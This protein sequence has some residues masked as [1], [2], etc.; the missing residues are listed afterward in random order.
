MSTGADRSSTDADRSSAALDPPPG[1]AARLI[2]RL[3]A[4]L[5]R[6]R[7]E[8]LPPQALRRVLVVRPDDRV[9]NVLLT[10]P[11]VRALQ[12]L[13]PSAQVELLLADR[14]ACIAEG[15]PG[16]TVVRFD[17][18]GL[19]R[20]PL[21]F[22]RSLARLR[23]YDAAIDA[24]HW[25]A[26]SLTAALL[27]RWAGRRA[28]VGFA[29]APFS[30]IYS[31]SLALPDSLLPD[32]L[33]KLALV[34]GLGLEPPPSVALETALGSDA[35]VLARRDAELRKLGLGP[36]RYLALNPGGRKADHRW[37]PR[38]F[39]AV[40]KAAREAEPR[41]P[42]LVFWGPG[43]EA[44]A[45]QVIEA[46]AGAATLAPP[47]DLSLL[48]AF[49]RGAACVVTNDTGPLHLAVAC[50]APVVALQRSADAAR[51]SHPGPRF[52]GVAIQGAAADPRGERT[53]VAAAAAVRR[54]AL[55]AREAAAER[56][57]AASAAPEVK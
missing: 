44:I 45:A 15:L 28:A 11:L 56:A 12:A 7:R 52:A 41:L 29:R 2:V 34:R 50:G 36:G 4:W 27:T 31:V 32:V 38:C 16:L 9:G 54:F 42:V 1:I 40:A 53:I 57:P 24:S 35:A 22:L 43:E 55:T 5:L 14:R 13:L 37:D 18:Q 23:S 30:G 6:S 51:W 49:F 21:R 25:H 39:G 47:T 26:F 33:T 20:R 48:A 19:F 3:A 46:S 17:K 8:P 10:I